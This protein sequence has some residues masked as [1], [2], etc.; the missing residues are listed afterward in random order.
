MSYIIQVVPSSRSNRSVT[1]VS[2]IP[3]KSVLHGTRGDYGQVN[4]A[5]E[6]IEFYSEAG[7]KWHMARIHWNECELRA[8]PLREDA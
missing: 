4:L 7:A 3:K 6:A 2:S 5:K 1:Y 8:V